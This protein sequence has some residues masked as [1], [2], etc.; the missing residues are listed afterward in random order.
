MN[1]LKKGVNNLSNRKHNKNRKGKDAEERLNLLRKKKK[2]QLMYIAVIACI[3][4]VSVTF[5]IFFNNGEIGTNDKD[6]EETIG[7]QN[8]GFVY[9]DHMDISSGQLHYYEYRAE[10]DKNVRYFLVKASDGTIRGAVDLCIKLHPHKSGWTLYED[11]Y[12]LC[13]DEMCIYPVTG[14]GTNQPGCCK[15][16]AL[17]VELVEDKVRIST[18]DLEEVSQYF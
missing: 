12:V 17:P 16:I 13:K 2:T 18:E 3:I 4:M 11:Y 5:F 8:D 15:P 9:F 10:N 1:I 7:D 14:I 6:I